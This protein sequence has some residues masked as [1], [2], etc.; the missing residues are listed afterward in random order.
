M[1]FNY[2]AVQIAENQLS[3]TLTA[4][5]VLENGVLNERIDNL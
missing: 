2:F 5:F 3:I 1:I 4:A